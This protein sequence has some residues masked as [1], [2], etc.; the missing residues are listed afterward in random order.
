MKT[1]Q[2]RSSKSQSQAPSDLVD[3]SSFESLFAD[4]TDFQREIY[5][6]FL[7]ETPKKLRQYDE[8][9]AEGNW[10]AVGKVAHSMKSPLSMLGC[11][12]ALEL[13][14]KLE[15][16]G[17][18]GINTQEIPRLIREVSNMLQLIF[19]AVEENL[20]ALKRSAA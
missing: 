12:R 1:A 5:I 15:V 2:S 16:F 13:V 7:E 6:L 8:Y 18:K 11:H 14:K 17:S 9:L 10:K 3:F 4:D 19:S 20:Q